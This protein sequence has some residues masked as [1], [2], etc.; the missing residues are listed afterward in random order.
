MC[1]AKSKTLSSGRLDNR[2]VPLYSARRD[3]CDR[4]YKRPQGLYLRGGGEKAGVTK[5]LAAHKTM[6]RKERP[7]K[8]PVENSKSQPKKIE[9]APEKPHK[10][11]L[12]E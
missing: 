2:V 5:P 10:K 11:N 8:R 9:N 7:G 12:R 6:L 1:C 4:V 3:T